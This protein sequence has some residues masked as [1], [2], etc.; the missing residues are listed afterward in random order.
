MSKRKRPGS[1]W[2]AP[3][4]KEQINN[5]AD[6]YNLNPI[7]SL[8]VERARRLL[9]SLPAREDEIHAKVLRQ[10]EGSGLPE[11]DHI[12]ILIHQVGD[13]KADCARMARE[14]DASVLV[15]DPDGKILAFTRPQLSK[16]QPDLDAAV[17]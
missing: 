17:N 3:R 7:A 14:L 5:N 13:V 2:H 6:T 11:P 8:G 4:P 9:K 1:R 10:L 16:L 12:Q 15:C